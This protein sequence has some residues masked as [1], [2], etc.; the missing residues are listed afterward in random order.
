MFFKPNTH[1]SAVLRAWEC[2]GEA[3]FSSVPFRQKPAFKKRLEVT[4]VKSKGRRA[5]VHIL[6]GAHGHFCGSGPALGRA[7]RLA[8]CHWEAMPY[9]A[10]QSQRHREELWSY[11][12]SPAT[13]HGETPLTEYPQ[14]TW[15]PGNRGCM[16]KGCT[17]PPPSPHT[18]PSE[19]WDKGDR[20]LLEVGA[21]SWI[22]PDRPLCP[23]AWSVV[24]STYPE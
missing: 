12:S 20:T 9:L 5:T 15:E 4:T 22:N 1:G 6:I 21:A 13:H 16:T 14:H 2:R 8:G 18:L 3:K 10:Q 17:P 19:H 23:A 11:W 24:G 7:A